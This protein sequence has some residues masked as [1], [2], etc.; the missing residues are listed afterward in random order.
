MTTV[1]VPTAFGDL[2][3]KVTILEIKSERLDDPEKLKNVQTEL[4]MLQDIVD[5][6]GLETD[7][8][9]DLKQGLKSVN[10]E[11]WDLEDQIRDCE[12]KSSFG[13]EFTRV[14]RSIYRTNDKRAAI[15]R[16]IN[17]EV[18]STLV[19]EKSYAEY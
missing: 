2:I 9:L 7:N 10:A 13:A 6:S 5:E 3:D 12:R 14:A 16:Q 18:G 1:Y 15:K 4:K 17:L 8:V 19:E 11:I